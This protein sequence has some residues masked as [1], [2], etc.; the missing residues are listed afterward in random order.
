MIF[1]KNEPFLDLRSRAPL[2]AWLEAKPLAS[3]CLKLISGFVNFKLIVLRAQ[4]LFS[5]SDKSFGKL[6]INTWYFS[7]KI[8]FHHRPL[9]PYPQNAI[10]GAFQKKIA[11]K[12]LLEHLWTPEVPHYARNRLPSNR[13]YHTIR[14]KKTR[15]YFVASRWNYLEFT[16]GGSFKPPQKVLSF[17]KSWYTHLQNQGFAYRKAL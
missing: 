4:K 13:K 17:W 16:I 3:R 10:S 8:F 5:R 12:W 2:D 9:P 11:P 14:L 15:R 7:K 6:R 1:V